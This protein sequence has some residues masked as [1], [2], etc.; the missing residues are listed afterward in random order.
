M[1]NSENHSVEEVKTFVGYF[2]TIL[3]HFQQSGKSTSILND[4]LSSIEM[5]ELHMMTWCPTRM[6]NLFTCAAQSVENILPDVLTCG[7]RP[8]EPSYF[9]SPISLI[10][11]HILADLH[12]IFVPK[13]LSKV[14][15]DRSL[16]YG[17][18]KSFSMNLMISRL[19]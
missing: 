18:S 8:E 13:F 7:I 1:S 19:H 2:R 14:D 4:A 5:K 3:Q 11:V 10:T 12:T 15:S 6:S 9:M 17:T 16:L